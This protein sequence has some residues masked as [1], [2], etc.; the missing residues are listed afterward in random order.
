MLVKE[1][2]TIKFVCQENKTLLG[3]GR[4]Y[5]DEQHKGSYSK[6]Y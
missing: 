2:K 4:L 1:I 6:N 3:F 5:F